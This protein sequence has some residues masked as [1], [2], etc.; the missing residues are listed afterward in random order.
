MDYK[1]ERALRFPGKHFLQ[2]SALAGN[3]ALVAICYFHYSAEVVH[4]FYHS[5]HLAYLL[6]SKLYLLL[7]ITL[8]MQQDQ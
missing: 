2:N 4:R 7:V 5:K 6:Y 3:P 8:F 1:F